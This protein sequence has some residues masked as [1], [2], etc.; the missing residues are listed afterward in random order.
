[1]ATNPTVDPLLTDNVIHAWDDIVARHG[2]GVVAAPKGKAH[3][4][5]DFISRLRPI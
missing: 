2:Q 4:V 1:M 3:S 5:E